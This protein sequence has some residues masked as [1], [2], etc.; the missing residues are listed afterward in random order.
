MDVFTG[1]FP[2]RQPPLDLASTV[3]ST[4]L[5]KPMKMMAKPV[6]EERLRDIGT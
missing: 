3:I 2:L 4:S 5:A 6:L 1:S